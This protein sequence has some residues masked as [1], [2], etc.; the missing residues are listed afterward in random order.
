MEDL[1]ILWGPTQDDKFHYSIVLHVRYD[2]HE[3]D[4]WAKAFRHIHLQIIERFEEQH[5]ELASRPYITV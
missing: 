3:V 4:K 5:V 2:V 1:G